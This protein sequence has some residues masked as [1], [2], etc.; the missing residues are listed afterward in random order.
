M[1]EIIQLKALKDNYIYVLHEQNKGVTAVV[2]PSDAATVLKYLA[3]RNW[4]LNFILN[5]HHHADHVGGNSHLKTQTGCSV[6]AMTKDKDRIPSVDITVQEGDE[7]TFGDSRCIVL[8]VPG[9]TSGDVA[10]WFP[11]ERLL[12]CG[13]SLFSLGCGRL[14]EGHAQEMWFSLDKLRALPL[15]TMIY[16]AHEYTLLNGLF[17]LTVEPENQELQQRVKTVQELRQKGL[18]TV[19]VSLSEE[20]ATNP[21]LRPES[22]A[23]RNR[24]KL[25]SVENWV[26]FAE[27]RRLKD[28]FVA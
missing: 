26:V 1:I 18:P 9:H 13:D 27:L 7:F 24:L 17:A 12:F 11:Y 6:I 5:T 10:Y 21:F 3:K 20:L 25:C 23:I 19:P 28:T 15:D 4:N 8:E 14:F 16:C 2:D 22:T